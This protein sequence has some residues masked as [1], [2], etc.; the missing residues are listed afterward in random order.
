MTSFPDLAARYWCSI[1]R[2]CWN[3]LP[4]R[5]A[6]AEVA[7][8]TFMEALETFPRDVPSAT[9]LYR[10]AVSK[11]LSRLPALASGATKSLGVFLPRF[12]ARGRFAGAAT[13]WSWLG[14]AAFGDAGG[15][16]REVLLRLDPVD[17]VA[18]VLRE[19]E[20][21]STE[22]VAAVLGISPAQVRH[23]VH[24]ASLILTGFLGQ[25]FEKPALVC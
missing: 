8:A 7:E 4:D 24:R 3:L 16:I 2:V 18:F 14:D 13:D 15:A 17:R 25:L 1:H 19:V 11:S 23:R 10:M 9:T 20:Q 21:L 5:R 6:A 22:E 12:D